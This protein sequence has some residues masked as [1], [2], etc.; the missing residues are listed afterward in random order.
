MIGPS[1][2]FAKTALIASAFLMICG[3]NTLA[4]PAVIVF[5]NTSATSDGSDMIASFDN[6]GSGP[7]A[8]SFTTGD[9]SFDLAD[10]S[11]ALSG[12]PSSAGSFNINVFVD[13][14]LSPGGPIVASFG[15]V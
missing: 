8:Q 12:M 2:D 15:T 13:A 11:V 5:N 10:L 14:G 7:L 1:M 4:S 9:T 6:G 3:G